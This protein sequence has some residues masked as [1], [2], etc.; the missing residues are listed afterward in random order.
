MTATLPKTMRAAVLHAPG[1]IANFEIKDLPVPSPQ[2]GQVLI[3]VHAFG[4]NRS[5]LFTRQGHSPGIDFPRVLGIEAVGVVAFCPGGELPQGEK[6]ATAMGGMGRQFDGGYAE[7]VVVPC[8]QVQVVETSL[9]WASLGAMPEMLQTAYGS[10]TTALRVQAGETLLI[11]GGTSSVGLAAAA[12]ARNM[13]VRVISTTR[14]AERRQLLLDQGAAEVVIDDGSIA[15]VVKG[16]YGRVDRVLELVGATTLLD[17]LQC[18]K[19]GG[20]CCMTGSVGDSWTLK[21]F[22]PWE[23]IPHATMFTVYSGGPEDFMSTPL[24]RLAKDVEEGRLKL[25]VGKVFHGLD[26][27]RDASELMEKNGAEGKIVVVV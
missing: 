25:P 23:H 3:R 7:Y 18:T 15:K 4:L 13:G 6:V 22:M 27:I 10:L 12:I 8:K 5:E 26:S 2:N 9:D 16:R 19:Q 17:S 24:S 14:R 11:R 20:I 21:D 1:P